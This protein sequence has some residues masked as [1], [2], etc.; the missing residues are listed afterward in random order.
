MNPADA[1]L[2]PDSLAGEGGLKKSAE[3]ENVLKCWGISG[4]ENGE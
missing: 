2:S 3:I 4:L 1:P